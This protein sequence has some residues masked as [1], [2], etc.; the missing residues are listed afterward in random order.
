MP[1]FKR[2]GSH[3][4]SSKKAGGSTRKEAPP[5]AKHYRC[6]NCRSQVELGKQCIQDHAH[7]LE[8]NGL[9]MHLGTIQKLRRNYNA[10]KHE[11]VIKELNDSLRKLERDIQIEYK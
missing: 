1:K 3:G 2:T 4:G 5:V 6:T 9:P 10:F 7:L 8:K 11:Y